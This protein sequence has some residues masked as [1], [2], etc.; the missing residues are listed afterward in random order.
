VAKDKSTEISSFAA[1]LILII[2]TKNS[3]IKKRYALS[4]AKTAHTQMLQENK[5]KI[6][7]IAK[8]FGWDIS[9]GA[10]YKDFRIGFII[11]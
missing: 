3:W 9:E 2:A 1:S 10:P 5:S 6:V 4:V 8:D 7:A 11:I